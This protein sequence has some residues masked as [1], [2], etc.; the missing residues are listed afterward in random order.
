MV[1]G[2]ILTGGFPAAHRYLRQRFSSSPSKAP[3]PAPPGESRVSTAWPAGFAESF[4]SHLFWAYFLFALQ[5]VCLIYGWGTT[6]WLEKRE[7]SPAPKNV[8]KGWQRRM[9]QVPEIS[10]DRVLL[11]QI[12]LQI[13]NLERQLS[14]SR[15]FLTSLGI[16]LIIEP[17]KHVR[18]KWIKLNSLLKLPEASRLRNEFL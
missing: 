10:F 4:C 8:S 6:I 5:G 9:G 3:A 14:L 11:R 18:Q 15:Q 7:R 1:A 12:Y 16:I 13:S 17:F 2:L